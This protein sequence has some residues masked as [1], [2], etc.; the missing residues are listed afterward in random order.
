MN[1][2]SFQS[3]LEDDVMNNEDHK[4]IEKMQYTMEFGEMAIQ[5]DF[6]LN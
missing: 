1:P 4:K 2:K 5:Y 3:F 6:C